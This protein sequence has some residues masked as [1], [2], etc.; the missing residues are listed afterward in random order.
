MDLT[1]Q[2][3]IQGFP[4]SDSGLHGEGLG[5]VHTV[6]VR[7]RTAFGARSLGFAGHDRRPA[8]VVP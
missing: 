4:I 8:E 1:R 2:L 6:R 7:V 5:Q 3:R